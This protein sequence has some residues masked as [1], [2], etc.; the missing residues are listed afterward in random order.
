[1]EVKAAELARMAGV[2]RA[3]VS[4]KIKKKTLIVNSAGFLDTE[5]PVNAAYISRHKRKREEAAAADYVKTGAAKSFSG[6]TSTGAGP[7]P[8]LPP[9]DFTLAQ[10]AGV[11]ARELLNMTLREIVLK[12]PGLDKIERYAKILKDT[13]MSAEREQRMN[14]R[15]LTLIPKDFVISRFFGF[16]ETLVKNL[17]EYPESAADRLI[18]LAK[19]KGGNARTEVVETMTSGISRVIAGAKESV[20]TELNSL[21]SKYQKDDQKNLLEEIKEAVEEARNE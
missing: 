4:E 7:P 15:S 20:I 3:S 12:Y 13:T 21:K 1:M 16:I 9:D 14:E 19:A 6:E 17:L 8:G 2:S 10:L 18:A 5:N 11:S